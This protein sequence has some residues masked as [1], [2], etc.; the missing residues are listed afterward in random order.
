MAL[1]KVSAKI[2]PSPSFQGTFSIRQ[3]K[4]HQLGDS[5]PLQWVLRFDIPVDRRTGDIPHQA[6]DR[7]PLV[8][9]EF[10]QEILYAEI[11]TGKTKGQDFPFKKAG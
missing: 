4:L 11:A 9:G 3:D 2:I 5:G 7:Q 8:Q 1:F 6:S 10:S